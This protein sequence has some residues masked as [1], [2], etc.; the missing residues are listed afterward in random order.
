MSTSLKLLLILSTSLHYVV[1][2]LLDA[3]V[4]VLLVAAV[5]DN[6]ALPSE[7]VCVRVVVG[8]SVA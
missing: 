3:R 6:E 4:V 8:A 1:V 2:E 5:V 7:L